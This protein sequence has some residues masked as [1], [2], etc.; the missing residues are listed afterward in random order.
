ME[1]DLQA[2]EI[3]LF[4]G[5]GASVAAGVPDTYSFVDKFIGSI[6]DSDKKETI[7]KIVEILK[8]KRLDIDVELLLE[9]LTK[10]SKR[11]EEPLLDFFEE[12]KFVL[13]K[14]SEK[15]PL[16][17]DL[18]NFIKS[19]AIVP[20]KKVQYLQPILSFI[21][22]YRP[23]DI[24]SL[25][26]DSCI[27]QFCNVNKL[28]YQDGFDVHWN[29]KNFEIDTDVRLYKVHGSV[30]WYQTDRGSYIKS[31]VMTKVSRIQLI[32]G[33]KAENL[34]L[35]PMQK[36]GY[37]E[38]LL[39]L[40]VKSKHLL[41]SGKCKFL[42]IV[43]YSFRDDHIRR[44]LWDAARKNKELH[45]ILIGPK[46]YQIYYEKLKYY[47]VRQ[48]NPSSLDGKVVCLP[49]LFEKVFPYLKNY[50]LKKL[51]Q[52][53]HNERD[54]HRLEIQGDKTSWI[55]CIEHYI[56]AEYVE[57]A[58]N[59]L[60]RVDSFELDRN[61]ELH[62]K[63][64][65]K[66]T[67]NLSLSNQEEKAKE[68]LDNFIELLYEMM[69]QRIEINIT[70]DLF[71]EIK[72]NSQHQQSNN[73]KEFK[74]VINSFFEFCETRR[75]FTKYNG[76]SFQRMIKIIFEL[77]NYL[78]IYIAKGITIENY[79]KVRKNKIEDINLFTSES[80]PHPLPKGFI[81]KAKS[82]IKEIEKN[83]LEEIIKEGLI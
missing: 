28:S 21:E 19:K 68:Y 26:Y 64:P 4:L 82:S 20:E 29:P 51:T 1:S 13:S 50:Y 6:K 62:L 8:R 40:I 39:E 73:V 58:E 80:Q 57:K 65:F 53:I 31:P 11:E 18:K 38:P 5:A 55:N 3:M 60:K 35:Y 69:V 46:S 43:G 79:V 48:T 16:I 12:K 70:D 77:N 56:N 81:P 30:M 14:Y 37:A 41:E 34:M 59:I 72:F 25:N 44:I 52:G 23:L 36:W 32:T 74:K 71:I 42:I 27:E 63:I 7:E 54:Q 22:D 75:D 10:L 17:D 76:I 83:I 61:L 78:D 66:L 15:K 2:S 9:T 49:Y 67:V 33:E 24:I 47:D 45:L